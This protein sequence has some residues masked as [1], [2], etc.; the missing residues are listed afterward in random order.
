MRDALPQP[1][2]FE[3]FGE[4]GTRHRLAH[5]P[6]PSTVF[7]SFS[8]DMARS[9]HHSRRAITNSTPSLGPRA[10]NGPMDR[11]MTHCL[12]QKDPNQGDPRV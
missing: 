9:I 3:G 6:A 1:H 2:G 5:S 12:R 7:Q 11:R 10:V 4:D 8:C